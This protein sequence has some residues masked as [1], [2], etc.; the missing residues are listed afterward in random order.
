MKVGFK[1]LDLKALVIRQIRRR[2]AMTNDG[3]GEGRDKVWTDV[4]RWDLGPVSGHTSEML[5]QCDALRAGR[6]YQRSLFGTRAEAEEFAVKMREMEPDQMFNVEA[7]KASA[8][9]N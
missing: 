2:C 6:L 9:W 1:R 8:V 3:A 7:I 5:W 4:V